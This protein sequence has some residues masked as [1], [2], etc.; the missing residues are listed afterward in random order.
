MDHLVLKCFFF[1]P[2]NLKDH[3]IGADMNGNSC[4]E[5][6]IRKKEIFAF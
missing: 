1:S 3:S 4:E 6:K 2:R 5:E